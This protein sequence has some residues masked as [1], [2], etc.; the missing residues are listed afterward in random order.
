MPPVVELVVLGTRE[1]WAL[2]RSVRVG[3][4]AFTDRALPAIR[5]VNFT[6]NGGELTIWSRPGGK[7]AALQGQVVAFEADE[8]DH[9]TRTG[10]TV[11]VLGKAEV[12]PADGLPLPADP[13]WVPGPLDHVIRIDVQRISGRRLAPAQPG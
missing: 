10:W 1:C 13:S 2:L 6:L 5:L 12:F 3:R 7:I 9:G 4:L 8:I 11:E